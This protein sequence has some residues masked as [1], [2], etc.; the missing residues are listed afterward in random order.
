MLIR[1]IVHGSF[2][3][4]TVVP[5]FT[6]HFNHTCTVS[7]YAEI[8]VVVHGSPMVNSEVPDF[9]THF[10]HTL[11]SVPIH[12]NKYRCSWILCDEFTLE[13]NVLGR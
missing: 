5:D 1:A 9:T 7:P 8:R 2:V 11:H 4:N 12:R 3:M 6:S 10:H 13:Q